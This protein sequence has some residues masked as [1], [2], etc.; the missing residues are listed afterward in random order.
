MFCFDS[1]LLISVAEAQTNIILLYL[2]PLQTSITFMVYFVFKN[3]Q[4]AQN[5][6][7]NQE[8]AAAETPQLKGAQNDVTQKAD[9]LAYEIHTKSQT[10]LLKTLNPT[11][12]Q[13]LSTLWHYQRPALD[14][15]LLL[16]SHQFSHERAK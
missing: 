16:L 1:S 10:A 13:D 3:L 6:I 8:S 9:M 14:Y 15:Q 2:V 5:R 7:T 11:L 12:L 4:M